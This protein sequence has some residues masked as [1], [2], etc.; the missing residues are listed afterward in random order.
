MFSVVVP[1]HN[2]PGPLRGCLEALANQD[3]SSD[4]FEVVVVDD[5]STG[6]PVSQVV[7]EFQSRCRIR[8]FVQRQSGPSEARNNGAAAAQGDYLAFTD[9]DCAPAQDWLSALEARLAQNPNAGIGG[10]TINALTD[11]RYAASSQALIDYLYAYYNGSRKGAR[12]FTSNNLALPAEQFRE[13]GGFDTTYTRAAAEDR[14]LCSHWLHRGYRLVHAPEARVYHRHQMS[15]ADF[16]RQHFNYG[17]GARRYHR[18]RYARGEGRPPLE[19]LAF[20]LRLLGW[21]LRDGITAGAAM[22]SALLAVSQFAHAAG[23]VRELA[24]SEVR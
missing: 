7:E 10:Q 2:R 1:T 11:N 22:Q 5:G 21:P 6:P 23:F 9:D 17:R 13:L 8:L 24:D 3:F 14:E 12:F 18:A 15:A 4:R 16:W 19:P 20:Y